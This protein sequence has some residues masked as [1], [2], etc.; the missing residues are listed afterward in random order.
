MEPHPIGGKTLDGQVYR[1]D[2]LLQNL[3]K[4]G[5]GFVLEQHGS[6]HRQVRRVELKHESGADHRG[7]FL[8]HLARDRRQVVLIGR[9]IGVEHCRCDDA[10]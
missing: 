4:L 1:G 9:V 7:V 2:V 8:M 10:G 3:D 5:I 6:L